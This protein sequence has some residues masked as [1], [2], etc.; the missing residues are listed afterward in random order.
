MKSLLLDSV[1]PPTVEQPPRFRHKV[2]PKYPQQARRA[3]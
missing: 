2:A 1:E 3:Q